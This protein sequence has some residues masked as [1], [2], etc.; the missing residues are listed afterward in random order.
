MTS[1]PHVIFT[2][3]GPELGPSGHDEWIAAV[4]D[5]EGNTVVLVSHQVRPRT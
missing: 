2:H 3:T 1:E 4:E 5:T